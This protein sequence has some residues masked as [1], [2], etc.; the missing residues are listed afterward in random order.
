MTRLPLHGTLIAVGNCALTFWHL[1]VLGNLHPDMTGT[2]LAL[3]AG[4]INLIPLS[5]AALLWTPLRAIA[6]WI[7]VAF[8]GVVIMIGGYEHFLRAGPDN[9]LTM[10]SGPWSAPFRLTAVLLV[11]LEALGFYVGLR[12]ARFEQA[13]AGATS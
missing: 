10:M 7:L 1:N 4:A 2:Q 11:L 5:A 13:A 3:F 6:G 9:V 12:V 8:F